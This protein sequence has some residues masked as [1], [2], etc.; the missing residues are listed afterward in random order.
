MII[1]LA[2]L[3]RKK[4]YMQANMDS[5]QIS[6]LNPYYNVNTCRMKEDCV[7][8][9][10]KSSS[11]GDIK[12]EPIY[13]PLGEDLAPDSMPSTYD[14][15]C[16]SEKPALPKRETHSNSSAVVS[17]DNTALSS[18]SSIS[19]TIVPQY[20]NVAGSSLILDEMDSSADIH[21]SNNDSQYINTR[22]KVNKDD[23][24]ETAD[25]YVPMKSIDHECKESIDSY[26][27]VSTRNADHD[28]EHDGVYSRVIED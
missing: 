14:I 20:K 4:K 10:L 11:F 7:E 5:D 6:H 23:A 9:D 24:D 3:R 25:G 19:H 1:V 17:H 8:D 2:I 13:E 16:N 22:S 21:A 15:P 27:Y 26:M 12:Q 28:H 18:T